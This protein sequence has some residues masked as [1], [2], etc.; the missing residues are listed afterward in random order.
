MD[1]CHD[2]LGPD[3]FLGTNVNKRTQS[4]K[5]VSSRVAPNPTWQMIQITCKPLSHA[6]RIPQSERHQ[7]HSYC[8]AFAALRQDGSVV[9]WGDLA[10]VMPDNR[11]H[12]LVGVCELCATSGAF[13]AKLVDGTVVMLGY[14][15]GESELLR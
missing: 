7:L 8:R 9:T 4:V 11:I 15:A 12:G 13:A 3:V 14:K 1:Q 2:P 6:V 10:D 5:T